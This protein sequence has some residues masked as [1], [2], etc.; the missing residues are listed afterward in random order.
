VVITV[1]MV[2]SACNFSL[3]LLSLTW[4]SFTILKNQEFRTFLLYTV[5]L[6]IGVGLVLFFVC[7]KTVGSAF[8][9]SFFSVI[10]AFT[11][12]GFFVSDYSTWPTFLC[13]ILFLLM[14]IGG[15]SGSTSGGVKIFR[16]LLFVKNAVLDLRRIIHPNAVLP[17]KVNDKA[18]SISGV[19]KHT[20]FIFV[21]FLVF[22]VG[23]IILL[24]CGID[25]ETA[26]G[27]SVATLSNVGTGIG[28]VGPNGSYVFFP[29]G[30][31]WVLMLLMVL[32]RV[33]LFSLITLLSRS[34]WRN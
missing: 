1:F 4:K 15:C 24:A 3:L 5:F 21:Y 13:V 19:Y 23:A 25:I 6:G 22:L 18:I 16:H 11:T 28:D 7:H 10:S 34:F 29:Q 2:L 17:V 14:F 9:E 31:K 33:E 32:G 26:L 8:R 30:V 20:T 27:A 12:T